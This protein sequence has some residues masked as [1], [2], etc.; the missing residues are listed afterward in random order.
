[1]PRKPDAEVMARMLAQFIADNIWFVA[2]AWMGLALLAERK[3][4]PH[5][6]IVAVSAAGLGLLT[7]LFVDW[8]YIF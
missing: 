6:L 8:F 3:R 7:L 5:S 4:V 2:A 1:M